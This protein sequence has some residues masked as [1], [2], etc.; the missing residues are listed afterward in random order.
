MRLVETDTNQTVRLSDRPPLLNDAELSSYSRRSPR[1]RWWILLWFSMLGFLQSATR[2][3]YSPIDFAVEA[4]Y[5][6][7][8]N[9]VA[10]LNN[11]T[12]ITM[13]LAIPVAQSAASRH[14]IRLPAVASAACVG[15]ASCARCLPLWLSIAPAPTLA[16][17]STSMALNGMSSA[18]L[19]FGGPMISSAWFPMDERATATA[20]MCVS[21]FIG[22]S[23]GFIIGPLLVHPEDFPPTGCN[24]TLPNTH[25]AGCPMPPALHALY[26]VEAGA[27]VLACLAVLLYF[28]S[29]PETPPT[30]SAAIAQQNQLAATYQPTT[31]NDLQ[32]LHSVLCCCLLGDRARRH[33]DRASRHGVRLEDGHAVNAVVEDLARTWPPVPPPMQ[34]Q[35]HPYPY[36]RSTRDQPQV[37]PYPYPISEQSDHAHP[38][39]FESSLASGAWL[40]SSYGR[41]SSREA[42]RR[43]VV[44]RVWLIAL[45]FALPNGCFRAWAMILAISTKEAAGFSARTSGLFGCAMT[46]S[47]CLGGIV[48]GRIADRMNGRALKSGVLACYCCSF[49]GFA[50]FASVVSFADHASEV[51]R[52]LL[53]VSG[54]LGGFFFD[55]SGPLFFEWSTEESYGE[56]SDGS[57]PALN[58]LINVVVQ[59]VFL[60]VAYGSPLD[61]YNS[62]WMNWLIVAVIP[63]V[64]FVLWLLPV[65]LRRLDVDCSSD[66]TTIPIVATDQP[67][68]GC[69]P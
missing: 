48:F 61:A 67:T 21:P 26:L 15:I 35:V 28:P 2:N 40:P 41:R 6:W 1:G 69:M 54:I 22:V 9:V 17:H 14:G 58:M 53:Y 44:C 50:T 30:R 23:A 37:D 16:I 33:G 39:A 65:S 56:L 8:A 24:A 10:W 60:A 66:T 7:D 29:R 5:G 46:L 62:V 20:L 27:C 4:I 31:P 38:P 45:A 49:V 32:S 59:V 36:P 43:R 3:F 64:W 52:W 42:V 12:C 51:S 55:A 11:V 47:G 25:H 19:S 13:I 18:F 34:P 68:V 57:G 63:V